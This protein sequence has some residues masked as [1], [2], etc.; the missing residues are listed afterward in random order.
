MIL[1]GTS[2]SIGALSAAA[3]APES[4]VEITPEIRDRVIA[5]RNLLD[6]FVESGRIIYGVSTSV[7]GFVNWQ[8]AHPPIHGRDGAEQHSRWRSI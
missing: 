1:D 5:S 3:R 4:Q 8:L 7:G 6:E 2:L